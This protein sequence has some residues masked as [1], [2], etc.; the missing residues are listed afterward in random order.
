M[1]PHPIFYAGAG[2]SG[3]STIFKQ[4]KII[5][6]EKYTHDDFVVVTP[7]VY[8]NTIAS[9]KVLV[10]QVYIFKLD[11]KWKCKEVAEKLNEV[12]D[13]AVID[14]KV[15][16]MIS[17][18]WKSEQIQAAYK[19]K[20]EFQLNDSAKYYFNRIDV[21]A[22][23]GYVADIN[24]LLRSRVRTSGIVEEVCIYLN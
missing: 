2:E 6:G 5:Y 3:K 13:E 20:S 23:E 15:G 14:E 18:L 7:V 9:M 16:K 21:I 8:N 22:S 11:K 1:S 10:E 17:T 19:R 24:D 4:M 12:D